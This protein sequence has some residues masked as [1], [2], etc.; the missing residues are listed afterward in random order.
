ME[1]LDEL[2]R[3]LLGNGWTLNDVE[4]C[5]MNLL[6]SLYEEKTNHEVMNAEDFFNM[7]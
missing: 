5:D 2:Y 1:S 6:L 3:Q 4:E 7:F